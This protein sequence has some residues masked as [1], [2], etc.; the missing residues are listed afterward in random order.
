MEKK[1]ALI[2]GGTSG[3]GLSI[4][5]HLNK[6]N[7]NVYFIGTNAEK[8][9]AIE[10][11][12]LM[13]TGNKAGFIKLD[14]SN[15]S[16]VYKFTKEFSET[17]EKLDLLANIAGVLIP[18]RTTTG[19]GFEKTL[20]IG[21]LSAYI[22]STELAPL[23]TKSSDPR[24][25]SV[26]GGPGIVLKERPD[27]NDMNSINDYK[28]IGASIKAVH[29]KTVL[30]QI[31]SERYAGDNIMVNSFHPGIVRSNLTRNLPAYVRILMALFSVFTSRS[32][33]TGIHVC[34]SNEVKNLTG[35]LF[36]K[37][38]PIDIKFPDTYKENLVAKTEEMLSNVIDNNQNQ[39]GV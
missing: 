21:Y 18:E 28:G 38:K 16:K 9:K 34:T 7:Y 3:V 31:L 30:T 37:D 33:Q 4:V 11:E 25:V 17:I 13:L 6:H 35:K 39:I 14:L 1:N 20:A 26:S 36:V 19:E 23:L 27:F 8:G 32:S 29:A 24:I 12:L 5:K 22:M 2:T 15:M 10:D